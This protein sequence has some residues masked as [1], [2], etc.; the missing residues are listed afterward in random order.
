MTGI[1]WRSANLNKRITDINEDAR[2]APDVV[3]AEVDAEREAATGPLTEPAAR[4]LTERIK[5]QARVSKDSLA[6]L[7]HLVEQARVGE[8]HAALGFSSWTAYLADVFAG[9]PLRLPREQRQEVVGY[10]AGEGLSTRA[11]APIVGASQDTV[12]KDLHRG[13]RNLSPDQEPPI[14]VDK[15]TVRNDLRQVGQF[16]PPGHEPPI[17]VDKETGEVHDAPEPTRAPERRTGLDGKSY[18]ARPAQPT[19]EEAEKTR[20]AQAAAQHDRAMTDLYSGMARALAVCGVYGGYD[21][22]TELM[23]EYTPERLDPPQ[24]ARWFET[25]NL[26]DVRRFADMLIEWQETRQ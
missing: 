22:I 13:E 4:R 11:I 19:P 23:A 25:A 18:P 8:A 1:T 6:K 15:E 17:V 20:Q 5:I 24:D 2:I 3:T 16:D 26:R 7:Q 10:L 12:V 9:E 14:V 21:N